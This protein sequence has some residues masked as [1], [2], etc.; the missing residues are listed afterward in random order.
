MHAYEHA[1]V[2]PRP[3]A[4]WLMVATHNEA[5]IAHAAGALLNGAATVPPRQALGTVTAN[6][7]PSPP[8][9]GPA[10]HSDHLLCPGC[11]PMHPTLSL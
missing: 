1:Y 11:S 8:S 9:R 4:T 5:S 2:V 6:P 7:P 10:L 3:D